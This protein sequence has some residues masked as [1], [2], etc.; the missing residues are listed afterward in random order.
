MYGG[1]SQFSLGIFCAPLNYVVHG[2]MYTYYTLASLGYRP[3]RWAMSITA[4]QITQM[5]TGIVLT[6][7][8]AYAKYTKPDCVQR[9]P[10]ADGTYILTLTFCMYVSYFVLFAKFY[11]D[12]Y[13]TPKKLKSL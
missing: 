4:L 8:A 6:S 10:S 3:S 11:F 13:I 12:R 1:I 7:V 5:V 2:Y 9:N